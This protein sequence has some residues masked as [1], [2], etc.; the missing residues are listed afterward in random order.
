MSTS[1]LL[2]AIRVVKENERRATQSY[3]DAANTITDPMGKA[4]FEN[5]SEFEKYHYERLTT[6]EKSLEE[7]GEYIEY[8]GREFPL[9]PIFEIKAAQKIDHKSIMQ[10]ITE[11]RELEKESERAYA[12]LASQITDL[13]GH[14]M[15]IKLSEEEH[16]HYRILSDAHWTLNNLGVWKWSRPDL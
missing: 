3:A 14:A 1:N 6:L 12:D 13:Q 5:L 2:D 7:K 11:A 9:P 15:F 16:I 8:D 4:L 10:I